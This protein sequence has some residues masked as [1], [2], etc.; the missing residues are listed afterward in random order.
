MSYEF[1]AHKII[2]NNKKFFIKIYKK[3]EVKGKNYAIDS[4]LIMKDVKHDNLIK[5]VSY[6]EYKD[7]MCFNYKYYECVDL[8][9]IYETMNKYYLDIIESNK[10]DISL[11]LINVMNFLHNIN[12]CHRDIK[13][14]N[15]LLYNNQ[16]LLCD[17]EYCIKC[18]NLGFNEK[19]KYKYVG[20][21]NYMPPEIIN[22]KLSINF[23]KVDIWNTGIVIYILLSKGNLIEYNTFRN[24]RN[25]YS[26]EKIE[27][28]LKEY[29]TDDK[30]L[31]LTRFFLLSLH[32]DNTKR[33]MLDIYI[34][35]NV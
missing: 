1:K 17:Y 21:I 19:I 18:N 15:I 31:D 34:K 2:S 6:S 3:K 9:S 5:M 8:I 12:I 4:E 35:N 25:I 16:I 14:D 23:K 13:L 30:L 20:T 27:K 7:Y 32:P 24:W 28:Y 22:E 11:Q 29:Y 26:K 10:F 33:E